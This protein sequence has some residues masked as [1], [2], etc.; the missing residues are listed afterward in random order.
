MIKRL[1]VDGVDTLL[2]PTTGPTEAGLAFRVGF[3]DEPLARRGITHLV[4]HLALHS[5]GITDYHYNGATGIEFTFFH[6]Q[7]DEHEIVA[8]L[9]GVCASLRNLP[10]Q[11]LAVEKDLLQAEANGRSQGVADQMALWRHGA[12]DYG[13]V[14]YP[15]WGLPAITADD[16]RTWVNRYFTR[17][18]AVLWVAGDA[19]PEDL[20]LDL[21]PGVRQP[22]P[23]PS[24]ALPETPAYFCGSAGGV[25]WDSVLPRSAATWVYTAVL[26]RM[27]FRELRQEGGLSYTVQTDYQPFGADQVIVTAV[28][29]ALPEKQGAVVGGFIDVLATLRVGRID[30]ADVTA[31]VNKRV[32]AMQHADDVGARLPGQA[33]GLLVGRE[34]Q[35]VEQMIADVRAVTVADVAKVAAAAWPSGL[36]MS[37]A[38]GDWAGFTL[39]PSRSE[40][41][42]TGASFASLE[43]PGER[44]VVGPEGVSIVEDDQAVTV[45]HE[46][47][48]IVRAWPDGGRQLVGADGIVVWIE[49]TLF[50][51]G[52]TAVPA[53]D[54][55]IRAEVRV[56]QPARDPERIPKPQPHVPPVGTAT[57]ED[58]VVGMAGLLFWWPVS[59][60]F[61]AIAALLFISLTT[62]TEEA[63]LIVVVALMCVGV[64]GLGGY[65]IRRSG[66]RR[67]YGR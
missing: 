38:R 24:S 13:T 26:E 45:R 31:V 66:R 62:D 50:A 35:D 6:M 54:A 2:A 9:N 61:G 65:F 57:S 28:A 25:V 20:R 67:R 16:L 51:D 30:P 3:V 48:V 43:T 64:T 11:R 8:F 27:L 41:A 46:D 39:A 37:P 55:G 5:V 29:D 49:P 4:E 53:I 19:V 36:M 7:G 60:F 52:H 44:L 32:D 63:G 47:C 14:S 18:N 23:R 10:M 17:E 33:F 15:E 56:E 42:V 58:R 22:T 12:R 1:A 34:I 21:P 59:L 40:S